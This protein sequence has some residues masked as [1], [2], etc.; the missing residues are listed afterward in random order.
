MKGS[1]DTQKIIT[2]YSQGVGATTIANHIGCHET[3]IVRVLRRNGIEIRT[4]A[5]RPQKSRPMSED[6]V[7]LVDGLLLGDGGLFPI[8]GR[9]VNSGFILSQTISHGDFVYWMSGFFEVENIKINI[10]ER[11]GAHANW[12]MISTMRTKEFSLLRNAW[13]PHGKKIVPRNIVLTVPGM[14]A[15]YLGDG[16]RHKKSGISIYTN[17]FS[18]D[19]VE[20]LCSLLYTTFN[21][22][23]NIHMHKPGKNSWATEKEKGVPIIYIPRKSSMT[24]FDAMGPCP[25]PSFSYKWPDQ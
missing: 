24:L 3:T 21:V 12:L 14:I 9:H 22:D 23:A 25:V 4:D 7:A 13:Y 2:L 1:Y 15:W 20:Y 16:T 11:T 18:V 19:D 5:R 8:K 10:S 17:S 6:L